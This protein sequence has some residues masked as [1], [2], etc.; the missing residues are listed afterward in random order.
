MK[1]FI[2]IK[3][4]YGVLSVKGAFDIESKAI[5]FTELLQE[6]EGNDNTKFYYAEVKERS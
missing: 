4:C 3:D 6:T 2:V 1:K 5:V